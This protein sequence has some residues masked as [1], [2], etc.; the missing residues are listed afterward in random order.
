MSVKLGTSVKV[1]C[2]MNGAFFVVYWFSV[3]WSFKILHLLWEAAKALKTLSCDTALACD[4][5]SDRSLVRSIV[6]FI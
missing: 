4:V 3:V 2:V 6:W 1:T 5:V